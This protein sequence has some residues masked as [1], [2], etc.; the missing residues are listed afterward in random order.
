[1]DFQKKEFKINEYYLI[2]KEKCKKFSCILAIIYLLFIFLT[3]LGY[4]IC[5]F[6][7]FRTTIGQENQLF[8]SSYSFLT[9]IYLFYFG[10]FSMSLI[11]INKK[12]HEEKTPEISDLFLGFKRYWKT[13]LI[14]LIKT[15]FTFLFSLIF[16]IPGLIK[17]Y[18]YSL[19]L[20]L[21]QDNRNLKTI[22]CISLSKKLMKGNKFKL[23][24]LDFRYIGW[25]IL[26]VFTLGI[27]LLWVIPRHQYSRY[28]FY[29]GISD[30]NK[31]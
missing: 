26:S 30:N 24:L 17:Y 14:F 4:L 31:N 9:L 27:L 28:L 7:A 12:I 5:D 13:F 19:T 22:E 25:Y 8:F 3:V 21:Y 23:F 11:M 16:I 29:L 6:P 10:H 2:S 1:M 18:S 15:L 20:Y